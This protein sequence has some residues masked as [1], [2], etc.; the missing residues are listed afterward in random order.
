MK[1]KTNWFPSFVK[2]YRDGVYEVFTPNNFA[3]KYAYYD[4]KGWRLCDLTVEQAKGEKPH[5]TNLSSMNLF[6][7]QWRGFTKEQK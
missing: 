6:K 3:N 4:K 2:P 5:A 1:K 7:S